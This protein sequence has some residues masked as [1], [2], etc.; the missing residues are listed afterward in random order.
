MTDI[1][2]KGFDSPAQMREYLEDLE[3]GAQ[4]MSWRSQEVRAMERRIVKLRKQV[5]KLCMQL[6]FQKTGSGTAHRPP[7]LLQ[8]TSAICMSIICW[9]VARHSKVGLVG[10]FAVS[11]VV[12]KLNRRYG[13]QRD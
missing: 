4:S 13:S 10:T 8:M 7:T 9:R 6:E 12:A 1:R 11:L 5:E 2:T 3:D